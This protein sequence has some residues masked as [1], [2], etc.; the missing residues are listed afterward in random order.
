[1]EEEDKTNQEEFKE[2]MKKSDQKEEGEAHISLTN[3]IEKHDSQSNPSVLETP[4]FAEPTN[5]D[6]DERILLQNSISENLHVYPVESIII[7]KNI[8]EFQ[9]AYSS[10][11]K[12]QLASLT[13]DKKIKEVKSILKNL[14]P[15]HEINTNSRKGIFNFTLVNTQTGEEY[16]R[17]SSGTRD[18]ARAKFLNSLLKLM[19][20]R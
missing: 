2:K 1:M 3:N 19:I 12:P 11:F 18:R 8:F 15:K 5:N 20:T 10:Y 17:T 14:K 4:N 9:T 6:Q 7:M 16:L 13:K